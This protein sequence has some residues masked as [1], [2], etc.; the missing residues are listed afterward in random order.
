MQTVLSIVH[1]LVSVFMILVILLQAGKSG[2]IGIA[3]GSSTV[4]GGR[5][6]QTF[7]EKITTVCAAIFMITSLT[8]AYLSS[9]T[10]SA[11]LNRQRNEQTK[12]ESDAAKNGA[13]PATAG[14]QPAAPANE[15]PAP[16]APANESPAPAAPKAGE[17]PATNGTK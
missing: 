10:D 8:L 16:A 13:T 6:S 12:K 17:A 15:S 2:G 14:N 3:G 7:L 9:R 11:V 5:G 1:V 4:F